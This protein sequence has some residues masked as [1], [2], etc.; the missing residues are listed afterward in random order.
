MISA[1]NVQFRALSRLEAINNTQFGLKTAEKALEHYENAFAVPSEMT[2]LDQ[3][4]LPQ[5]RSGGME[6]DAIIF[7]REDYFLY[8]PNVSFNIVQL[9]WSFNNHLLVFIT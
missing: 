1:N 4:A 5:F 6:N 7:Y 3:V 8:E 9:I 2:K